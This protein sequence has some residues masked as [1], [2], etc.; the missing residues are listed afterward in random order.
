M[1][2]PIAV[3]FIAVSIQG[4]I[5]QLDESDSK[6]K[7][8]K[9]PNYEYS[10][11]QQMKES[12]DL[13]GTWVSIKDM[14]F[15]TPADPNFTPNQAKERTI[16][17]HHISVFQV[18]EYPD[19][20]ESW[21]IATS[22]SQDASIWPTDQL[23][24]LDHNENYV[25]YGNSNVLTGVQN[26]STLEFFDVRERTNW[27]AIK[28][29]NEPNIL[30][31]LNI[32]TDGNL[33]LT[34]EFNIR[35]FCMWESTTTWDTGDRYTSQG[36]DVFTNKSGTPVMSQLL[37]EDVEFSISHWN[38]SNDGDYAYISHTDRWGEDSISFNELEGASI[39]II[40]AI[41]NSHGYSAEFSGASASGQ[42]V[43]LG[44]IDVKL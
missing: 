25:S 1:R 37:R 13:V 36:V 18:L 34:G 17:I 24:T 39:D 43:F 38:Q 5:P 31:N 33:S 7:Q 19:S 21:L 35:A 22:C 16:D 9:W 30:G 8:P 14:S 40:N 42:N 26:N 20:E 2:N 6:K 29:S 15:T 41:S 3:F 4:C 28:I 23:Q 10:N 12:S 44:S 27:T 11:Y 32:T